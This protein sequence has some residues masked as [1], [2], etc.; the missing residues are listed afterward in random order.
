MS[1]IDHPST[2]TSEISSSFV[3][4][5]DGVRFESQVD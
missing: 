2:S 3:T 1:G 4:E 5:V